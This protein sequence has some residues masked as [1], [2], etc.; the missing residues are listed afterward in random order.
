[1]EVVDERHTV[2]ERRGEGVQKTAARLECGHAPAVGKSH[3]LDHEGARKT[4]EAH[5]HKA[6]ALQRSIKL[7]M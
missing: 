1:M 3:V 2:V 4:N 5:T 7:G 6:N